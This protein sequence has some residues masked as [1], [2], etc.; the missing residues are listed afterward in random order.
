[1]AASSSIDLRPPTATLFPYTTLFRSA[2]VPQTA[3]QANVNSNSSAGTTAANW[4]SFAN[5]LADSSGA[6]SVLLFTGPGTYTVTPP[7]GA[8]SEEH[9]SE[10]QSRG[11]L[12]CNLQLENK[13]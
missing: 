6:Y 3:I 9:T 8:R 7:Q 10:L 4:T 2:P 12:V 5:T 13:I 11:H 1:L